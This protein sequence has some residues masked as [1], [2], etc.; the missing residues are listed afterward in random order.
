MSSLRSSVL[1]ANHAAVASHVAFPLLWNHGQGRTIIRNRGQFLR[2][3]EMIFRANDVAAIR[4]A[5]PRALFC[6]NVTQVMLGLGVVWGDEPD[7]QPAVISIN[8]ATLGERDSVSAEPDSGDSSLHPECG[9][10]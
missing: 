6:R 2:Y 3:Y 10:S 7:G 4:S 9:N 5:D 8:G 1:D